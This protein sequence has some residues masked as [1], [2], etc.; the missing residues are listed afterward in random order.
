MPHAF[1]ELSRLPARELRQLWLRGAPP[2]REDLADRV[3]RGRNIA[4]AA[5][6]GP[7]GGAFAKAFFGSSAEL[8]GCN[9]PVRVHAAEWRIDVGSPYGFFLLESTVRVPRGAGPAPSLLLDYG[10]GRAASYRARGAP[11]PP[12]AQRLLE[13]AARPLR[14]VLVRPVDWPATLLLGRAYFSGTL[15]VPLN[16]FVLEAWQPLSAAWATAPAAAAKPRR[17]VS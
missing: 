17:R 6:S 13:L 16:F 9:F 1:E 5:R 8:D 10:R 2:L 4:A 11:R 15:G 3:F 12:L 7:G 14:E